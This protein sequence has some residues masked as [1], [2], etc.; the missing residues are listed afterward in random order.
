MICSSFGKDLLRL[1]AELLCFGVRIEGKAF[2]SAIENYSFLPEEKFIHGGHLALERN[3]VVNSCASEDFTKYSPY[4]VTLENNQLTLCKDGIP[5]SLC[6]IIPAPKWY[7]QKTSA[8]IPMSW[9]FRQH[10]FDVLADATFVSC[11]FFKTNEE[12][13]FCSF[14]QQTIDGKLK[15]AQVKET[16]T[17]ALKEN[18]QYSVALSE[19]SRNSSDRGALYLSEIIREIRRANDKIA[20]SVELSPPD[21]NGFLDLLVDEG[22]TAIIMNLELY[23]DNLRRLFCPG[24]SKISKQRYLEAWRYSVRRLGYG[25]VSSVLIAGL[26][27]TELTIKATSEMIELG[28][29]PTII[30]FRPYDNCFL[31]NFSLTNPEDLIM[32]CERVGRLLKKADMSPRKQKGCTACGACSIEFECGW[33]IQ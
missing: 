8:G 13:L 14:P 16:I 17:E 9:I 33:L 2:Q 30:P 24:K 5:Y 12:C 3:I 29:I 20:I 27:K 22:A 25:N 18:P 26:E 23:D 1:K 7:A 31:R 4:H 19:G 32:I 15:L 6:R 21:H 11:D 28:V 10:G